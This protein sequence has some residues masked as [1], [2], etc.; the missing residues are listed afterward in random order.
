MN[1]HE[2]RIASVM[3]F[4]RRCAAKDDLKRSAE[5]IAEFIDGRAVIDQSLAAELPC[6]YE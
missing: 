6:P 1:E 2:Q 4:A 5:Q 3:P